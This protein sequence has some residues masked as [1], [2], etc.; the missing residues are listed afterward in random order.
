MALGSAVG[1]AANERN[2]VVMNG[3]G[4]DANV[5]KRFWLF[6]Y[7]LSILAEAPPVRMSF[8]KLYCYLPQVDGDGMAAQSSRRKFSPA[9]PLASLPGQNPAAIGAVSAPKAFRLPQAPGSHWF[10]PT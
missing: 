3:E 7:S 2:T 9:L 5:N 6:Q 10:S 4:G 8:T 1:I